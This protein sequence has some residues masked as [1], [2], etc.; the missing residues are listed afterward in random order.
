MDRL[1]IQPVKSSLQDEVF[2]PRQKIVNTCFLRDIT[3]R[4]SHLIGFSHYIISTNPCNTG[5]RPGEGGQDFYGGTLPGTIRPPEPK[6]LPFFYM[7]TKI[8]QCLG[9]G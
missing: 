5:G 6:Y 7:D 8:S 3:Y 2:S 9:T 4:T 1:A